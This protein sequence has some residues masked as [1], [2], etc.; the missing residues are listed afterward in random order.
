MANVLWVGNQN[1]SSWSL[2]P[3][4]VLSWSGLEFETRVIELG[5]PGY[6]QRQIAEVLAV[7]PTGTVPALHADGEVISD[8][9]AI[10]EWAAERVPALWPAEPAAR[11]QARAAACEM[12]SSFGA[13]RSAAPCNIR[14]R[15]EPRRFDEAVLRDMARI[16]ALW[17]ALRGRFGAGGPYL[18]GAA[19]TIADAFY[20]PV[21]TRCRTYG[22]PLGAASQRYVDALLAEP[23]FR[24]WE[25]AAVREPSSMPAC[26]AI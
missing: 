25:E 21:A 2:R 10:A 15:A 24:R 7:S 26:D 6:G 22:I 9:L 18:F 16:E 3:W 4:L 1:Y 17:S 23:A 14:R 8:S 19:P 20:T 12:H 11:A 5:R 13:L